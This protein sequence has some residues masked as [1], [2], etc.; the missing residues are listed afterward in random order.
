MTPLSADVCR[1]VA[2]DL[3]C[4]QSARKRVEVGGKRPG[5]G[6]PGREAEDQSPKSS[7]Q[8]EQ[9]LGKGH[10]LTVGP[11]SAGGWVGPVVSEYPSPED[12]PGRQPR[13][14]W[15]GLASRIVVLQ[16]FEENP[17]GEG[18]GIDF[19]IELGVFDL[20]NRKGLQGWVGYVPVVGEIR[21][22]NSMKGEKLLG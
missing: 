15:D 20:E 8:R 17:I 16:G 12:N 3:A 2:H 1:K 9:I 13:G 10:F 18:E 7:R 11:Y 21:A 5:I 19:S 14:G 4:G 6:C 22:G